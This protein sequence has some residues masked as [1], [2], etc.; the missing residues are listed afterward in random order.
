MK[1]PTNLLVLAFL[2][3]VTTTFG[4][5]VSD[6]LT[7]AQRAYLRGDFSEAREKFELV[8]RVEPDNRTAINYLRRIIVEQEK[9]GGK[10]VPNATQTVL[11]SVILPRLDLRE[12]SLAEALEFLR[13]KGNQ[14]AQ[15]RVV[16]NFVMQ[17]DEATKA[18]KVTLSL[19]NVPFTEALRYIGELANV[20][21]VYEKFAIAVRPKGAPAA[22]GAAAPTPPAG[23]VRVEG[24]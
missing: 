24:L 11:T 22:Q 12:A 21:F 9:M 8:R 10:H 13:Q 6:L 5:A 18:N 1:T 7:E 4:Q 15:G 20:Q 16:I 3:L 23:G 14:L 2:S 19:Q 17:I